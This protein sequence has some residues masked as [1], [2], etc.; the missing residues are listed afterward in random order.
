MLDGNV[1]YLLL[2]IAIGVLFAA[3]PVKDLVEG[4]PEAAMPYTFFGL[5]LFGA[6]AAIGWPGFT[7]VLVAFVIYHAVGREGWSQGIRT[8]FSFS[9]LKRKRQTPEEEAITDAV[10]YEEAER[11]EQLDLAVFRA[12][13]DSAEPMSRQR[14]LA[15]LLDSVYVHDGEAESSI[16]NSIARLLT[17]DKIEADENGMYVIPVA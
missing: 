10:A 12:V 11:Y 14:I 15:S 6:T 16:A 9:W 7:C 2:G 17:A 3:K 13:G 1:V 4:L 5:L 8:F